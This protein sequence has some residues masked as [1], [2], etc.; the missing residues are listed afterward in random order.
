MKQEFEIKKLFYK[1]FL[2]I[3]AKNKIM[4]TK[5]AET[6]GRKPLPKSKKKVVIRILVPGKYEKQAQAEINVIETKYCNAG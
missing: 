6:R 5:K 1:Y 3:F 4:G 2:S